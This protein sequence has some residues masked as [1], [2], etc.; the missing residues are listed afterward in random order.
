M[1]IGLVV[2]ARGKVC[3]VYDQKFDNVPWYVAY[4]ADTRQLEIFFDN[5]E[6]YPIDW[7]ATDEMNNF[8]LQIQKI[9]M[10]RME[11]RKPVEGYDVSFLKDHNGKD[12]RVFC[13]GNGE[14]IYL[15]GDM[16]A[17]LKM[18]FNLTGFN[19]ELIEF[20]GFTGNFSLKV[21]GNW[22][23]DF[24]TLPETFASL[25]RFILSC[26]RIL[27]IWYSGDTT[28]NKEIRRLIPLSISF[29]RKQINEKEGAT[30]SRLISNEKTEKPLN[31]DRPIDLQFELI[32]PENSSE[33]LGQINKEYSDKG[34]LFKLK[35]VQKAD[36]PF[37]PDYQIYEVH[38]YSGHSEEIQPILWKPNSKLIVLDPSEFSIEDFNKSAPLELD[39]KNVI[40]YVKFALKYGLYSRGTT[41][42]EKSEDL[43][44]LSSLSDVAHE[45]LA[46]SLVPLTINKINNNCFILNGTFIDQSQKDRGQISF[47]QGEVVVA[48]YDDT[49]YD[50]ERG[51]S[52]EF[53]IGQIVIFNLDSPQKIVIS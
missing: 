19:P 20:D 6:S 29:V 11:N 28:G 40:V 31:C 14:K 48:R 39:E 23:R 26:D 52:S 8:L 25:Q 10:I 42:I 49:I 34:Q 2:N 12:M 5:G 1:N 41:I 36:L 15:N 51:A 18:P 50:H 37:Y 13:G 45:E 35:S 4:H 47:Y 53:T 3:L 7:K 17:V 21:G 32:H 46:H 44:L 22:I 30:D 9:L 38:Y 43:N 16:Q 27:I 33:F 24:I